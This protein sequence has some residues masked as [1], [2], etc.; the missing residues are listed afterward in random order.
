MN[1]IIL[2][3]VAIMAPVPAMAQV[4]R[5]M[6]PVQQR[7]VDPDGRTVP[8]GDRVVPEAELNVEDSMVEKAPPKI[9]AA[10]TGAL[11]RTVANDMD[12]APGRVLVD[13]RARRLYFGLDPSHVRIYPVAVGKSG[14]QWRGTVTVGWKRTSPG[15]HPTSRQRRKRHLPAYVAPGRSNPLGTHAIYLVRN[16]RDTLLRIHGT[17]EP[18]SIGKAVSSGCIRMRNADVS[19]LYGRVSAG[20]I[21]TAR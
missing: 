8:D 20:T 17:N 1:R 4:S 15:W 9:R 11:G 2:L 3:A 18:G 12:L 6:P 13:I 7:P 5:A 10:T 16:G 21:V 14:A 19:D